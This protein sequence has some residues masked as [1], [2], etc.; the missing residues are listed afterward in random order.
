MTMETVFQY[1]RITFW[2]WQPKLKTD[3]TYLKYTISYISTSC[4]Y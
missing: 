1:S 3:Q 2:Q 4:V